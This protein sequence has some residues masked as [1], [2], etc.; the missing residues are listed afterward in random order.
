MK[1]YTLKTVIILTTKLRNATGEYASIDISV[2]HHLH[3]PKPE[4]IYNIYTNQKHQR[5]F[6]LKDLFT[7][8][9]RI[10]KNAEKKS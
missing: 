1:K 8:A 3:S 7:K 2:H 5:C 9:N 10:I 6:G 4:V